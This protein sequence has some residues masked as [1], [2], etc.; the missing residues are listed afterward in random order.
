MRRRII[1]LIA[2]LLSLL[3][4]SD[5]GFEYNNPWD[6]N[7][8]N[9]NGGSWE[10]NISISPTDGGTASPSF[11]ALSSGTYYYYEEVPVT[12]TATAKDGYTFD[13]WS[14]A[15]TATNTSI[16]ITMDTSK[17]LTA[18]FKRND[19]SLV[20]PIT[21][22]T[23]ETFVDSRDSKTYKKVK[24]G[25]QTW[26]AQNLNYDGTDNGGSKIGV[27]YGNS[28]NNCDEYGRLY[29][30]ATAMNNVLS[31]NNVPSGVKGVCDE[32]WHLPSDAEW[33]AL[34]S[35]VEKE[36]SC[37]NCAGKHLKSQSGWYNNGNGS[38]S[39]GF[40][41]LHGGSGNSDGSFIDAGYYGLWWSVTQN[42]AWN[43]WHRDM[44]YDSDIVY[45][46]TNYKTL[47][48]SVRCVQD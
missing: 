15:S 29:N 33:T 30:W 16:T 38:D 34:V 7:A 9:Y 24:I 31:S 8:P 41:A 45:R 42:D 37:S 14:G 46:Y 18:N 11:G 35:Y 40:S 10:L 19:T 26:M 28:D 20:P 3:S 6:E 17:V 23:V 22:P 5:I 39:Y 21:Q 43:A 47:L 48:F 25:E 2:A 44:Y 12:V 1:L 4:C 13:K 32:G 36:K 27:C